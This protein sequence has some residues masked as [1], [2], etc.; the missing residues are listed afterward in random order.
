MKRLSI[1]TALLV[2]AY[3]LPAASAV[4]LKG[5]QYLKSVKVSP[6]KARS[7]ALAVE[8]GTLVGWELEPELGGSGLRY[9]FDIRVGHS[10]REVGIDAITGK[11]LEDSID[12]GND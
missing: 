6:A 4:P 12:T 2:V 5:T 7:T 11:V 3:T 9:S 8:R 10:V 1:L